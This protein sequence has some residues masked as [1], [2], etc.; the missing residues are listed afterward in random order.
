MGT[1][2]CSERLCLVVPS[3]LSPVNFLNERVHGFQTKQSFTFD[4]FLMYL[5][6]LRLKTTPFSYSVD[7]VNYEVVMTLYYQ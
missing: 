1:D 2:A 7:F 3:T 4:V 6:I 5:P